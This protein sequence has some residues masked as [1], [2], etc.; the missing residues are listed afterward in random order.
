MRNKRLSGSMRRR[1]I[2]RF[3]EKASAALLYIAPRVFSPPDVAESE[4]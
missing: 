2:S 1:E 3:A 4:N